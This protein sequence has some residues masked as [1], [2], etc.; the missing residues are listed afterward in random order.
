MLLAEQVFVYGYCCLAGVG[1]QRYLPQGYEMSASAYTKL[2]EHWCRL[3]CH[4]GRSVID[5]YPVR[6]LVGQLAF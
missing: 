1:S 6:A 3:R 4:R 2:E 5:G